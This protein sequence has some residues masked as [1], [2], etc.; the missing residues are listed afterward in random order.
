IRDQL[1]AEAVNQFKADAPWHLE[2]P[3]LEALATVEQ[4]KRFFVDAWEAPIREWLGDRTDVSIWEVLEH[5]LGLAPEQWSQTAQKR[6]V[7]ILTSVRMG[8]TKHRPRTPK[9]RENR[10]QRAA[11]FTNERATTGDRR[12]PRRK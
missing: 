2:T 1:W 9:G 7:A 4:A 10:Y 12:R 11:K 6:V 5:A 8:F 3:E